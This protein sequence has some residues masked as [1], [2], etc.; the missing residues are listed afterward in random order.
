MNQRRREVK[1]ALRDVKASYN[2]VIIGEFALQTPKT[3]VTGA[4]E[5]RRGI[6]GVWHLCGCVDRCGGRL[7]FG[8]PPSV[9]TGLNQC[10]NR[11]KSVLKQVK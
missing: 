10:L 6:D 7:G 5:P 8:V 11:V 4:A 3:C 1:T 9:K 2:G